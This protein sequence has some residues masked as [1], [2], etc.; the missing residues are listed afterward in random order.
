MTKIRIAS[1]LHL[2]FFKS[3]PSSEYILPHLD[4]DKETVLVL[5]GDIGLATKPHTYTPFMEEV[6][7]RFMQVIYV[8]GNHEFYKGN[9]PTARKKMSEDIKHLVNVDILE[10]NSLIINNIA[11]VCATMWTN[12][13][14]HDIL[15][16]EQ[17]R[18]MM[19]DY[20]MIRT[21]PLGEP[22]KRRLHPKDTILDFM[23]AKRFI[24]EEIK[25]QK[26][27]GKK[28]VV[29]THHAPS[30]QS[31]PNIYKGDMINGA[32]ASELFEDIMD[33]PY[34]LHIHGHMHDNFDY[35][36]GET[37]VICNPYGYHGHELNSDFIS[38]LVIEI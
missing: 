10:K 12:M 37:R 20:K 32:F 14:K 36:I 13:N 16:I 23:N 19:N 38:T 22:W 29:V 9:F 17:A 11:F 30:Y 2:E 28:V 4:T 26:D 5:A 8:F 25:K 21:G 34:E 33:N 7:E 1:D 3:A 27:D 15:C 24:F 35:M 6:S 18:S 31:I